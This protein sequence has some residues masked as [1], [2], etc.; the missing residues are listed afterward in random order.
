MIGWTTLNRMFR[1]GKS[2]LRF[3]MIAV[4]VC[5]SIIPVVAIVSIA[6]VLYVDSLKKGMSE[7]V[8]MLFNQVNGRLEEYFDAIDHLSKVTFYNSELQNSVLDRKDSSGTHSDADYVNQFRKLKTR[9]SPFLKMNPSVKDIV[10]VDQGGRM[11]NT[12]GYSLKPPMLDYLHAMPKD[13]LLSGQLFF[14][15]SFTHLGS[16]LNEYLA[17][18]QIRSVEKQQYMQSIFTGVLVLDMEYIRKTVADSEL[19]SKSVLMIVDGDN[20]IMTSTRPDFQ[21]PLSEMLPAGQKDQSEKP[22]DENE[23]YLV[24]SSPVNKVGWRLVALI[25]KDQ[26]YKDADFLKYMLPVVILILFVIV[27]GTTLAL[28]WSMTAPIIKLANAFGRVARGDFS[29]R[30]RFEKKN[31]ITEIADHFNHMVDE[32][33]RLTKHLLS[34]QQQVFEIELEKK[35]F[36]LSGLQGQINAHFLFNTLSAIRGMALTGEKR[37]VNEIVDHLA[38]YFRYITRNDEFVPLAEEIN[39]VEQYLAIYRLR[40]GKE[41][42]LKLIVPEHLRHRLILKLTLQPIVENAVVYGL[43]RSEKKGLIGMTVCEEDGVLAVRVL[44]NGI[45]M[46]PDRLKQLQSMLDSS[47]SGGGPVESEGTGSGIGLWNIQKRLQL[48]CGDP[49]GLKLVSWQGRGTAVTAVY[50]GLKESHDVQSAADR[51]RTMGA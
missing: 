1:R 39:F 49:F 50:P 20:R 32:I 26:L 3:Q 13:K 6:Y 10:V 17:F 18:R 11:Y 15:G 8:D 12:N 4:N 5:I 22:K 14:S 42:E 21:A 38:A 35:Q 23:T 36:Q 33:D 25:D 29:S 46:P 43:S 47:H 27:V 45:G 48:F 19:T 16:T 7:T 30:L 41:I 28:N 37:K 44:D 34:T 51:R 40:L 9:L 31:E 2:S 24:K